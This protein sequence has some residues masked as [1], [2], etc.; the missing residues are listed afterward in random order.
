MCEPDAQL[1]ALRAHG[2][3]LRAM[4]LADSTRR[5]YHTG[6]MAFARFMVYFRP[7]ITLCPASDETLASFVTF[8]SQSCAYST[9]KNYLYGLREY[10]LARGFPFLPLAE[11]H[12]VLWTLRGVRRLRADVPQ[13]KQAMTIDILRAIYRAASAQGPMQADA[14]AIWAAMLV[15][16]FGMLRKDNLTHGKVHAVNPMHG[17]R[18]G[19]VSF[20]TMDNGT[21]GTRVASLRVRMAKNNPFGE[22]THLVPLVASGGWLCPVAALSHHIRDFPAAPESPMFVWSPAGGRRP[23]PLL[24]STFVARMKTM[25][26]AAGFNPARFAG[27]SLRRGGATLAFRLDCPVHMIQLQGDWLSDVVYRYHEVSPASRLVL[28]YA[29]SQAVLTA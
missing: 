1:A 17:L 25:L 2:L 4:H 10:H 14:R 8:Q 15:G 12:A 16:F 23:V 20:R 6:V 28:P 22:R 26:R 21:H 29:M 7:G 24:H 27:H 3:R 18:R 11:R 5:S 9:L 13:P 19:D